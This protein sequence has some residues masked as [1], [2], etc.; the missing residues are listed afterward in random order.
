MHLSE[1]RRWNLGR[2]NGLQAEALLD[3]VA[4]RGTGF[5]SLLGEEARVLTEIGNS[6]R[7]RH[8]E[9]TQEPVGELERVDYL[10]GRLFSFM[11]MVLKATG[12]GG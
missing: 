3:R 1:P 9:V 8:S 6:F 10:F 5:R 11:R 12:R 7:I 4:N 2:T